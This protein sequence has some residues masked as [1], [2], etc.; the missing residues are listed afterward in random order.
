MWP[1]FVANVAFSIAL[2]CDYEIFSFEGIYSSYYEVFD[3]D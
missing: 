3:K 1:V 2:A